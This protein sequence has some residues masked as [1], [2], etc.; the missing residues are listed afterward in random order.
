MQE[1]WV[2]AAQ[3]RGRW[4]HLLQEAKAHPGLQPMMII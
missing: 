3:V 2:E 1:N 4:R